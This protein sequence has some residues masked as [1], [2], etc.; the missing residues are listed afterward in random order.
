MRRKITTMLWTTRLAVLAFTFIGGG[1]LFQSDRFQRT[2]SYGNLIRIAPAWSWGIAYLA[3]A[4]LLVSWGL[5]R[6]P[7][8]WGVVVHTLAIMLTFGW[9]AAFVVRYFTDSST[10]IVNVVSWTVFL[11][12]LIE[13]AF[14]IYEDDR[15]EA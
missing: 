10:T 12:L 7:Q 14:D 2:P 5:F 8:W 13:S 4:A 6:L 15:P 9:L 1:L 3:A 11:I